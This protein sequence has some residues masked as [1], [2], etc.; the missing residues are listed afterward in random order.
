MLRKPFGVIKAPPVLSRAGLFYVG[1]LWWLCGL[2]AA[3]PLPQV[4]VVWRKSQS[5]H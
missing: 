4:S 1:D 2:I 5:L 3:S